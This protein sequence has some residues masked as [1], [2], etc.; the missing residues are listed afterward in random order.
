MSEPSLLSSRSGAIAE[1]T[2]NRPS[3]KNALDAALVDDLGA[4]LERAAADKSVR[5]I[6]LGGSG[7][8]FCSGVDLRSAADDLGSPER[9]SQR[10]DGFHRLIRGIVNAPKP[11]IAAVDGPAV[12]FGAELAFACDLRL[13]STTA[14]FEEKFSAIGLMPDGGGSFHLSRLLGLARTLELLLLGDRIA[15]EA[16]LGLGLV[17]CVVPAA[18][19]QAEA[20]KLAARLAEGP[21]LAFAAIK[22]AVREGLGSTLDQALAREREGQLALLASADVREGISSFFE[23]RAPQFR[24]E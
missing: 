3:S 16:A 23:R 2:L 17:R 15:A 21:P 1:L 9:L 13:A 24:G 10:L 12:G 8:A 4:A 19:L 18:E 5:V 20:R 14:Y 11:V 22:R 6:V 7:G